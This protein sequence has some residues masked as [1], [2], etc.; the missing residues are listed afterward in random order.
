MRVSR[1]LTRA[2]SAATKKALAATINTT[3]KI[4]SST[5]VNME[6]S[7]YHSVT[8]VTFVGC[9]GTNLCR[10][11]ASKSLTLKQIRVFLG[12]NRSNGSYLNQHSKSGR[13]R[14]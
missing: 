2:N 14:Q 8:G 12:T 9:N 3:V 7:F 1:T 11:N 10:S 5:K 6:V 13:G 4:C